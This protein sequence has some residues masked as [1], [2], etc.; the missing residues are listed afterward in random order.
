M[1]MLL[2]QMD[3]NGDTLNG[4]N[5]IFQSIGV[6]QTIATFAIILFIW[7][8]YRLIYKWGITKF[9]SIAIEKDKRIDELT[10]ILA[11]SA[12]S[13]FSNT[14]N[15]LV[16]DDFKNLENHPF[17]QNINYWL[18]IRINQMN[19][20]DVTKSN[21]FKDYVTIR[22]T[23]VKEN[24]VTFIKNNNIDKLSRSELNAA[25]VN[26]LIN[27]TKDVKNNIEIAKFP[28]VALFEMEKA[29]QIID[30]IV[31]SAIES[32]TSNQHFENGMDVLYTILTIKMH[33]LE[34][35]F[36]ELVMTLEKLNGQLAKEDYTPK[37]YKR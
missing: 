19:M 14:R 31:I 28:S 3:V 8:C 33:V 37:F 21:I 17:F 23:A 1:I 9:S 25:L 11:E 7:G 26:L 29:V 30:K 4:I 2:L 16:I 18:A 24:W 12:K 6:V 36:Y 32:F 20:S 5:K 10:K 34:V 35:V 13:D 15:Y 22:Y 27:I